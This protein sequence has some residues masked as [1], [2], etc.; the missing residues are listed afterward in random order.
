MKLA[1]L[2]TLTARLGG[3]QAETDLPEPPAASWTIHKFILGIA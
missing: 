2:L 1:A 3:D